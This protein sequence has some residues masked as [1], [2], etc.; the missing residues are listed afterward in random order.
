MMSWEMLQRGGKGGWIWDF[1]VTMS[2]EN[3]RISEKAK[4]GLP[5]CN[6]TIRYEKGHLETG[7]PV[8]HPQ[9][10]A[11]LIRR[12]HALTTNGDSTIFLS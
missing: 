9:L 4:P 3:L 2:Q 12:Q 7:T 1:E 6:K 10:L 8:L 11:F 5:V